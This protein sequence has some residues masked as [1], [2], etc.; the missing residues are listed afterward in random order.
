MRRANKS[1][2]NSVGKLLN[3][4]MYTGG[5]TPLVD[6]ENR[7]M[8]RMKGEMGRKSCD[9]PTGPGMGAEGRTALQRSLEQT[10]HKETACM[11]SVPGVARI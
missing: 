7:M 11:G 10:I 1:K 8:R 4:G 9:R 5:V 2:N 3:I 6:G